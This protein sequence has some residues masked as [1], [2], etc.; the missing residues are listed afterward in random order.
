MNGTDY[1]V[2]QVGVPVSVWSNGSFYVM[3]DSYSVVDSWTIGNG[4]G[5]D[6]HDIQ[7]L[8]NGNAL[9]LSYTPIPYDLNPYG[10]QPMGR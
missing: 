1:L 4:Y 6:E 5:A 10:G 3:D 8:P 9:M 7:L 2:Y